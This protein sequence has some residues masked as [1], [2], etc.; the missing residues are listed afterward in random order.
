MAE[1]NENKG[2]FGELI[3]KAREPES[4]K[5]GK[6]EIQNTRQPDD[7]IEKEKEVNLCIKVPESWRRHWAAEAK[8]HGTTMNKIVV[9]AFSDRFGM[10][11]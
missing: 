7:V 3:Q 1:A 4:H 11:D 6:Q 10:P 9:E 8:R 5:V 2:R